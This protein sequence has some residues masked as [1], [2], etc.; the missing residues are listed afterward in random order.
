M[1]PKTLRQTNLMA[2]ISQRVLQIHNNMIFMLYLT[3]YLPAKFDSFGYRSH[4]ITYA[5]TFLK[6]LIEW[7]GFFCSPSCTNN[8]PKRSLI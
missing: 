8:F 3:P 7:L 1:N 6:I 5:K 4:A 2:E